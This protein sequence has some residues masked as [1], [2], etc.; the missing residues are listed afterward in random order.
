[1]NN[2]RDGKLIATLVTVCDGFNWFLAN[3]IIRNIM[4]DGNRKINL[5]ASN[6]AGSRAHV[7]SF[8]QEN[9][10]DRHFNNDLGSANLQFNLTS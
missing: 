7:W 8:D 3:S 9:A 5:V 10:L 2:F 4:D 6:M 1:M